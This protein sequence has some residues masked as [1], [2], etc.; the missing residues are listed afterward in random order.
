MALVEIRDF[1]QITAPGYIKLALSIAI[2][3]LAEEERKL[4]PH[5]KS[6]NRENME[7]IYENIV[8]PT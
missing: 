1:P 3:V 4:G 7:K 2:Q 8:M 6:T 5:F